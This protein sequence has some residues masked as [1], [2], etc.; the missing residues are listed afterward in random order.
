MGQRGEFRGD[1]KIGVTDGRSGVNF[2]SEI[3]PILSQER[4]PGP[5]TSFIRTLGGIPTPPLT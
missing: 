5:S 2:C 3:T 1:Y 4:S